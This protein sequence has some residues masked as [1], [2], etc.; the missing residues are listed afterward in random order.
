MYKPLLNGAIL[1]LLYFINLFFLLYFRRRELRKGS[2]L[3]IYRGDSEQDVTGSHE[4]KQTLGP[5]IKDFR[6]ARAEVI[7][8][9]F[10]MFLSTD[11]GFLFHWPLCP[12]GFP[13][14]RFPWRPLFGSHSSYPRANLCQT[15]AV[16]LSAFRKTKTL[17]CLHIWG[18]WWAESYCSEPCFDL[19]HALTS[20]KYPCTT[21]TDPLNPDFQK[22]GC[23]IG[24]VEMILTTFS[25]MLRS[26]S[27]L[28]CRFSI[29]FEREIVTGICFQ[30]IF[31]WDTR[32]SGFWEKEPFGFY[33]PG[34]RRISSFR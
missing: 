34:D 17:F 18:D 27:H 33:C 15:T 22:W 9:S 23:R 24:W 32:L 31:N 4:Y 30:W 20:E 10:L 11:C 13:H 8:I 6:W 2:S 19:L 29:C 28:F 7:V 21:R 3:A 1:F 26:S 12:A 16:L 25:G 14:C 5:L